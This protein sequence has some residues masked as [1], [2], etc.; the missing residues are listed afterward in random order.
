MIIVNDA[1]KHSFDQVKLNKKAM[2]DRCWGPLNCNLL[3]NKDIQA[4][5]TDSE[6][7]EYV[8]M[9]KSP[10]DQSTISDLTDENTTSSKKIP[11]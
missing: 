3:N 11:L 1:W 8:S 4:T 2:S 7:C 10:L 9:L 6:T 5:I